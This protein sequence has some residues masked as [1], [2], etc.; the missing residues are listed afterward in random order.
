MPACQPC[1][2]VSPHWSP[3]ASSKA[4]WAIKGT[5]IAGGAGV[6]DGTLFGCSAACAAKTAANKTQP[7]GP[8]YKR[9]LTECMQQPPF[10]SVAEGKTALLPRTVLTE[11]H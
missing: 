2:L 11:F 4:Q 7:S 6:A 1:P 9:V 10:L 5:S 8:T 3:D